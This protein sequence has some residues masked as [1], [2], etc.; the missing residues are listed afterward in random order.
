MSED[1]DEVVLHRYFKDSKLTLNQDYE[2][3][4]VLG[5]GAFSV[6]QRAKHLSS[7]KL[8]AIKV[9]KKAKV[10]AV[11]VKREVEIWKT[12][13]N[14]SSRVVQLYDIY[15]N[16][17]AIFLVMEFCTGGELF[18][19]IV[20]MNDYNEVYASKIMKQIFTIIRDLHTVDI[21]HQDLKPE[22]LLLIAPDSML[23]KLCDFGLAE[24]A[25]DTVELFGKVGSTTYMAPE[26]VNESGH[27]K[28][29]DMYAAGVILY[30]LLCG[31]P[32]FEPDKGIVELEF[33]DLEWSEISP[34]AKNLISRLLSKDPSKRGT[35]DEILK[36]KWFSDVE[37]IKNPKALLGTIDSLKRQMGPNGTLVKEQ[38][39]TTK[40]NS[41]IELFEDY[42]HKVD[43]KKK[44]RKSS[45][46]NLSPLA[47]SSPKKKT[48]DSQKS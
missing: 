45:E 23:I 30:I 19:K 39:K 44:N 43:H 12:A 26:V 1:S 40:R 42:K 18:E 28:P 15:E 2:I 47:P 14:S 17:K 20:N 4:D 37:T 16:E 25:D 24:I 41:I 27:H 5:D 35:P 36:D 48:Y 33:P 6:V 38:R 7:G 8:V 32:P 9:I 10:G 34:I 31:Y 29:V 46:L 13:A 22:N 11:D 21:I 3:Q